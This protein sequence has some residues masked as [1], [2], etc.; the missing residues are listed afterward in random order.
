MSN[1]R[2]PLV[3]GRSYEN[4]ARTVRGAFSRYFEEGQYVFRKGDLAEA[5]RYSGYSGY[6]TFP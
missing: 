4:Y 2:A 3:A 1:Q 6:S 5:V